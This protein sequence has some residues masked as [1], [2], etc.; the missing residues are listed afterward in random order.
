MS[1]LR[2]LSWCPSSIGI[3]TGMLHALYEQPF[4]LLRLLFYSPFTPPISSHGSIA[5]IKD[6]QINGMHHSLLIRGKSSLSPV[7]LV[8]H[9]GPGATDLPFHSFYGQYL[10]ENYLMIHYDQRGSCKSGL[11]NYHIHLNSQLTTLTIQNHINDTIAITEWIQSNF[12]GSKNGIYLIGGSWGSMLALEAV[13]QRP[14]LFLKVLLRGAVTNSFQSERNGLKFLQDRMKYFT[15]SENELN[16]LLTNLTSPYQS[17]T[18]LLTQREYLSSYGGM[19]YN[20]YHATTPRPRWELSHTMAY[21]LFQCPEISLLEIIGMKMCLIQSLK[22][23]WSEVERADMLDRLNGKI[24]IPVAIV[25]GKYDHCT[26]HLLVEEFLTK[27]I[28]PE[29]YLI[30]FQKSG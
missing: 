3:L 12:L 19:D 15:S 16:Y 6:L 23:M 9:G 14:D 25:H 24:Q 11:K 5:M 1:L 21:S 18:H 10:E 7:I 17:V 26:S 27:L 29:K 4:C 20:S 13:K 2:L 22:A 8:L 28:A 30:W